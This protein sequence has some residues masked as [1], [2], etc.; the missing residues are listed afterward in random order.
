[1]KL[2]HLEI[3]IGILS[4]GV[5]MIA[6]IIGAYAALTA[7]Q[8]WK[9]QQSWNQDHELTRQVLKQLYIVRRLSNDLK[10]TSSLMSSDILH[11]ERRDFSD[12]EK[13]TLLA[14]CKQLGAA[15]EAFNNARPIALAKLTEA[16]FLWG[17][18][19]D[20]LTQKVD[21]QLA[22][23]SLCATSRHYI[24]AFPE[25]SEDER[26]EYFRNSRAGC[27]NFVPDVDGERSELQTALNNY[28]AELKS[29]LGRRP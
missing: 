26:P 11:R 28:E 9:K 3:Y 4:D 2:N 27:L 6:A 12:K 16:K 22:L 5:I 15:A 19:F 18:P 17:E 7:M 24:A 23:L 21:L 20:K 1:M 25:T 29:K 13:I 8:T 10:N 14:Y